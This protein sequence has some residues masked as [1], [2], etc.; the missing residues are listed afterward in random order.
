M[1][2]S[3]SPRIIH[4]KI[5]QIR[6][7]YRSLLVPNILTQLSPGKVFI[8]SPRIVSLIS[9]LFSI[10]QTF[11]MQLFVLPLLSTLL[12]ISFLFA[13]T[14]SAASVTINSAADCDGNAITTFFL[15]PHQPQCFQRQN[16]EAS[17][18]ISANNFPCTAQLWTSTSGLCEAVACFNLVE[19]GQD[20]LISG[21]LSP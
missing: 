18:S 21:E 12:S 19:F 9:V 20:A 8:L 17:L 10:I 2:R 1:R 15:Q 11:T 16:G 7:H 4:R 6:G 5:I 14:T 13:G 3:L